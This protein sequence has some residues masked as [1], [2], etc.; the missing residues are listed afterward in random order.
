VSPRGARIARRLAAALAAAG[1]AALLWTGITLIRG[2]PFTAVVASHAQALLRRDLAHESRALRSR[3]EPAALHARAALFRARLREGAAF[4]EIVIP[5]VRL[6]MVVVEGTAAG[7]LERGPGHYGITAFP[8]L[9][10]TIAIAGHRTTYLA[11]FR[12]IDSL[13]RGNSIYLLMPY[14][15]FRYVVYA[16]AVVDA[17]DWSIIRR[18]SFEKLVLTA[19]HPVYSASH[20]IVVFARLRGRSAEIA[21][22]V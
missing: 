18:S 6:H 21:A 13:R 1:T 19:C 3:T 4:G 10:G 20:R 15:T 9:G 14:G 5:R 11:P 22:G 2:E 16:T 8:G 12:H 7:D 17:H